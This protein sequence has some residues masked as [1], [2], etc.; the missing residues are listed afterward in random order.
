MGRHF[1]PKDDSEIDHV[2][3]PKVFQLAYSINLGS[4]V[5]LTAYTQTHIQNYL[6]LSLEKVHIYQMHLS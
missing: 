3:I 2:L 5:N 6:L 1:D 4:I